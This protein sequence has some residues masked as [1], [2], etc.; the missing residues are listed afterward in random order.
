MDNKTLRLYGQLLKDGASIKFIHDLNQDELDILYDYGV[1]LFKKK[2][3]LDAKNIFTNLILIDHYNFD[4]H[5]SLGLVLQVMGDFT[6][7]LFCFS[8]AGKINQMEPKTYY[9]LALSYKALGFKEESLKS[10]DMACRLCSSK[11]K[12]HSLKIKSSLMMAKLQIFDD[13]QKEGVGDEMC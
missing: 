3:H 9:Y 12:F 8:S 7:S 5:F 2:R 6:S 4:Y 11:K 13:I 1:S 10:L